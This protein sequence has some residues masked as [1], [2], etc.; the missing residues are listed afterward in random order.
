MW[1]SL[2]QHQVFA[3]DLYLEFFPTRNLQSR[4]KSRTVWLSCEPPALA[5]GSGGQH[6]IAHCPMSTRK[7]ALWNIG[8]IYLPFT[9][10]G[11]FLTQT[12]K[13]GHP[14]F[15]QKGNLISIFSEFEDLVNFLKLED[16]PMF[17]SVSDSPLP[18]LYFEYKLHLYS[19]GRVFT[20]LVTATPPAPGI[21]PGVMQLLINIIECVHVWM[22]DY[23]T[24]LLFMPS[25]YNQT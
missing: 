5:V 16:T 2:C 21:A 11:C 24:L 14:H 19:K 15:L 3:H 10:S 22:N 8:L 18:C 4:S 23:L 13:I 20:F 1:K 7:D 25:L 6:L 9:F 12:P 17:L